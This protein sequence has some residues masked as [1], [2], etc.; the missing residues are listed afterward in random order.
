MRGFEGVLDEEEEVDDLG[1]VVHDEE[2]EID[3]LGS[4]VS[5]HTGHG[6][7]ESSFI[8]NTSFIK[9]NEPGTRFR[10]YCDAQHRLL[11]I[12]PDDVTEAVEHFR[13]VEW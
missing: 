9:L 4:G 1:T 13:G 10:Q 6:L 8:E 11:G 7:L 2:E 5:R 12:A 3:D